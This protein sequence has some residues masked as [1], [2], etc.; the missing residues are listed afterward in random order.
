[1]LRFG[2]ISLLCCS[3]FACDSHQRQDIQLLHVQHY[4]LEKMLRNVAALDQLF[5]RSN[6]PA[7]ERLQVMQS[8]IDEITQT[9]Q[10]LPVGDCKLDSDFARFQR[11]LESLRENW[12]ETLVTLNRKD[13]MNSSRMQLIQDFDNR[14]AYYM[15]FVRGQT[16]VVAALSPKKEV[17]RLFR[18]MT[19]LLSI[20]GDI[21]LSLQRV[22][23]TGQ[24]DASESMKILKDAYSMGVK[25]QTLIRGNPQINLLPV[26]NAQARAVL[27]VLNLQYDKIEISKFDDEL[28]KTFANA[29]NNTQFGEILSQL[30]NKTL[31][32]VD[33]ASQLIQ[34][35]LASEE[36]GI[37]C[38]DSSLI[39]K[40]KDKMS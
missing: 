19:E 27:Q 37:I 6:K 17:F 16:N 3:L 24:L 14:M 7:D 34:K 5:V 40:I 32:E 28:Q 33:T 36:Q 8:H 11:N 35:R 38:N 15:K 22:R 13:F 21:R 10:A 12:N 2:L 23:I 39:G 29:D 20:G 26:T 18:L 31:L 4:S 25:L 1:M 9:L 30:E